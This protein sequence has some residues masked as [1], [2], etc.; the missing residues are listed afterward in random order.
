MAGRNG[1]A[2]LK[3]F[4]LAPIAAVLCIL[5]S[6][7]PLLAQQ[8]AQPKSQPAQPIQQQPA[9]PSQPEQAAAPQAV[10]P[11]TY[12]KWTKLCDRNA[13]TKSRQMC[14]IGRDGRLD[15]GVPL[16]AAV[17]IEIEGEPKRV[18][19]VTVPPGVMLPRG[20]RVLVDDD[21]N[22]A[23][24]APFMVCTNSGCL[25]QI[26][27]DASAIARMKKGKNL[28]IQAFSMQQSVMTLSVPLAEFAQAYDGPPADAKQ[29]E[30]QNNKLIEELQKKQQQAQPPASAPAKR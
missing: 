13:Q 23:V 18:L 28:Y 24:V 15:S 14:R 16:V 30:E 2:G 17:V 29:V 5:A 6:G 11:L 8:K 21:E 3:G 10:P 1:A 12:S 19:Q 20:T 27:T 4:R 25:A 9:A 26:E 22:A 7:T